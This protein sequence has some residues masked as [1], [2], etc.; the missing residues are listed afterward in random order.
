VPRSTLCPGVGNVDTEGTDS[1]DLGLLARIRQLVPASAVVLMTAFGSS[2]LA[3]DAR[4]LGA[5]D[6]IS[7]PFDMLALDP[8]L[9]DA[10]AASQP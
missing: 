10:Y 7:K 8:L 6:V 1:T 3:S 2:Q 9:R 4:E 5:Y